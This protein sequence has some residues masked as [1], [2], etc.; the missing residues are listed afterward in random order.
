MTHEKLWFNSTTDCYCNARC[1]Q[2]PHLLAIL[3]EENAIHIKPFAYTQETKYNFLKKAL[4][5]KRKTATT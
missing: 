2:V 3:F 1:D 5:A 4:I